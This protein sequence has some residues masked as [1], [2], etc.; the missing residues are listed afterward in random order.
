M[1]NE[2]GHLFSADPL[3]T[4]LFF[5]ATP[6]RGPIAP[7]KELMLAV[8]A[9]A[10]ECFYKYST[11]RDAVGTRLF[12]EAEEWIFAEDEELPFS[13]KNICDALG[14]NPDYIRHGMLRQRSP[15]QRCDTKRGQ[16]DFSLKNVKRKLKKISRG[17][18][19][20]SSRR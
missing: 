10:V 20:I 14:L 19:L 15:R 16:R 18:K 11:A 4:Q 1:M 13:F 8:L 6:S 12:R 2:L 7:E 5:G 9:D 17:G 3:V